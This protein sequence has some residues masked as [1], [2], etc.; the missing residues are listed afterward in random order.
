MNTARKLKQFAQHDANRHLYEC[1][2]A[3]DGHVFV[4]VSCIPG[5]TFA[6]GADRSGTIIDWSEL[7]ISRKASMTGDELMVG[8]GY[9]V[10]G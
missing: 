5:E 6:F 10:V 2:P 4:V 3:L 7:S 9:R 8:A 1:S